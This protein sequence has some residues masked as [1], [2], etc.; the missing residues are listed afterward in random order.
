MLNPKTINDEDPPFPFLK[1]PVE[2]RIIVYEF[3][4]SRS[5]QT[6]LRCP[7][8]TATLVIK[9]RDHLEKLF[10]S[11]PKY[12]KRNVQIDDL[13]GCQ[14][15]RYPTDLL[16]SCRL[17]YHEARAIFFAAKPFHY[18][19]SSFPEPRM[20]DPW[21][22]WLLDSTSTR[23][24]A[25]LDTQTVPTHRKF[26]LMRSIELVCTTPKPFTP[27]FRVGDRRLYETHISLTSALKTLRAGA[28]AL[29]HLHIKLLAYKT[30]ASVDIAARG[31]FDWLAL[32]QDLGGFF[33][34]RLDVLIFTTWGV[35]KM[36]GMFCGEVR[37]GVWTRK[38]CDRWPGGAIDVVDEMEMI[39]REGIS[40]GQ[41]KRTWRRRRGWNE[42]H[43]WTFETRK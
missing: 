12:R 20:W 17:V 38:K 16:L 31:M 22:P 25:Y 18:H 32:A 10:T 1:L 24:D 5:Q 13:K 36:I 7:N 11:R 28:P 40:G 39:G 26:Y 42:K 8:S 34:E 21:E 27:P 9:R 41:A 30:P 43:I 15:H 37:E 2:L 35:E 19:A 4:F 14:Y 33:E 29:R 3:T 6:V 23:E